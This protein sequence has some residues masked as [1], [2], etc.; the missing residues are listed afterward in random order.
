MDGKIYTIFNLCWQGEERFYFE[1]TEEERK[2]YSDEIFL[3]HKLGDEGYCEEWDFISAEDAPAG[4]AEER[5]AMIE[6]YNKLEGCSF[7]WDFRGSG[8]TLE[9]IKNGIEFELN[10]GK[11]FIEE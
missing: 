11:K 5:Q 2:M 1:P 9:T 6:K 7:E 3:W 8:A 4:Y 10:R